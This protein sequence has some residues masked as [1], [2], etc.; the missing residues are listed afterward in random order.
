MEMLLK[1]NKVLEG[2]ADE[3]EQLKVAFAEQS[4]R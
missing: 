3:H 1:H 2:V 4:Q